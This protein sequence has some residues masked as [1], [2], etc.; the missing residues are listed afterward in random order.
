[1]TTPVFFDACTL[2]PI[3]LTDLLLRLAEAGTYRPL[4]SADVLTEVERTLPEISEAMTPAK[5]SHRVA[6][7]RAAFPD[8]E[9]TG[10]EARIPT[11]TNP[12]K[13]RHVLAAAV[14][15]RAAVLVTANLDDFPA[16]ARQPYEIEA[17]HPDEFLL[18]QLELY[19]TQTQQ[20]LHELVAARHRPTETPEEFLTQLTKTVPRFSAQARQPGPRR[21]DLT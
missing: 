6:V 9:V 18:E 2:V 21:A 10:Y 7:M 15:A 5:A 14:H 12:D 19:P 17:V 4:W 20:C 1:V 11:M 8:A 16:N 3:N 13:D